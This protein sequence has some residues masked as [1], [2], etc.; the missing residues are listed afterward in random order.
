[1]GTLLQDLRYGVRML[2]KSPG[3]TAVVVLTL[4]LGIGANTAIFSIIDSVLLRP[5]PYKD[6]E[7]IVLVYERTDTGENDN[8]SPAEFLDY[9][10]E[11]RSLEHLAA[12]RYWPLNLSAQDQAERV[13]AAVVTNI[14]FSV[15]EMP[16]Q[17]GRT[18]LP[19]VDKPGKS[20][21]VV[22]SYSL[23]QRRFGGSPDVIGKS[24]TLDGEPFT[25][26]GVMPRNF[27]YP[28]EC[29][30]WVLS[31]YA[32]PEHPLQA[33]VDPSGERGNHYFDAVGRL[34]PRVMLPQA[35]AEADAI[36]KQLKQQ[37]GSGEEAAGA[38]I[39]TLHDDAVG[40]TRP[41]LLI[42]FGAVGLLLL[43]ACANVANVVLARGTARRKEIAIRGALGAS[44]SRIALQL[45][46]E[47][48]LLGGLGGG[49]GVL[50]A[51]WG[52]RPLS[53]LLPSDIAVL[54]VLH[55]DA[56]VLS[57]TL[58]LSLLTGLVSGVFPAL[59]LASPDL[60][61]MLAQGSH[62][63]SEPP[64]SRRTRRFLVVSEIALA[65]VLLVGAGL[66]I[67][68]F[69][70]VQE[71]PEGFDPTQTLTM[72]LSLPQAKYPQPANRAGFVKQILEPIAELPGMSSAAVVSRLP[73]NAGNSTRSVQIQGRTESPS[74]ISPDY[75]VTTP[76]YFRTVGIQLLRG[77]G[78]SDRDDAAAQP[79]AVVSESMARYFWP[80]Q[81]AVGKFLKVGDEKDWR[82]VVGVVGDIRQ[83]GLDR[84]PR[85]TLYLPYS[86]DPWPFMALVVRTKME[87]LSATSA[88]E[89][90]IHAVDKD[91]PLYRVRSMEQVVTS[92]LSTRRFQMTL[93]ALFA[94]LA[95]TLACVGVYG[96][97]AYSVAQRTHEI[98]IRVALGAQ[99]R[100]V[101]ALVLGQG[102][103]LAFM[104]I[105]LGLTGAL[106]F[107]RL[108]S[109]LLFGVRPTDPFVFAGV[110]ILL[111]GVSLAACYLPAR[112]AMRVDPIIA[113]RYE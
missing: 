61:E 53:A 31:R 26:V 23:W 50:L 21:V 71:Q 77:R 54:G 87:A 55:L 40:N 44:R 79:A 85:P 60:S 67:K 58:I 84:A 7:R 93:V 66:L 81:D 97:M 15:F 75:L 62:G 35:R 70:R 37:Y 29:E 6:P 47:S 101:L 80:G 28:F 24:V 30:L 108:L 92:S 9:Q 2:V 68:S 48:T 104:G 109:S 18:F 78:F 33:T 13:N 95:V 16:P 3:F 38:N 34:K 110:A 46:I 100:D 73:L 14:F 51:V 102:C 32:V 105:A 11:N 112:R 91:E 17:L 82:Q 98:G 63:A 8:L 86:Q 20:R 65:L 22:L 4:G 12:F 99:R 96:V 1:M 106:G 69:V 19:G 25:I 64:A 52:F 43:I 88:V 42:L 94:A 57:F 90:A 107:A 56:R 41:A 36:A 83:H 72:Q 103:R 27:R 89:D 74:D 111:A 49:L 59:H 5:L 39:V 45:L 76:E 113:L 10:R